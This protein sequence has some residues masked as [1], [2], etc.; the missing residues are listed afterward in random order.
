MMILNKWEQKKNCLSSA[1]VFLFYA[2]LF[3]GAVACSPHT[4]Q[5]PA[6]KLVEK[7]SPPPKV[8][9]LSQLSAENKPMITLVEKAPKPRVINVT[10][11]QAD[12][13]SAI[14][15]VN[16]KNIPR[17][18]DKKDTAY[19]R[20]SQAEGIGF[21]ETFTTDHGLALDQ[22]YCS[23]KDRWG[24]LWFG[25]NGGGVSKYDGKTFTTFTTA[26]GLGS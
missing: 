6:A 21:F 11:R 7:Q 13:G 15:T 4:E 12:M 24:N 19:T 3:L 9:L 10:M 26:H 8:I 14:K 16:E 5:M 20:A 1:I 23:Y 25:T 2:G 17:N 18:L 22:V